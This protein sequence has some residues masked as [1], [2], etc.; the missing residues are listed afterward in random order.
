MMYLRG[1]RDIKPGP[2][3]C[4]QLEYTSNTLSRSLALNFLD[5]VP[6][7]FYEKIPVSK[8]APSASK[9]AML[10]FV[11]C[12]FLRSNMTRDSP[13]L[14]RRYRSAGSFHRS[15]G[16]GD[17][18]RP[19]FPVSAG[20]QNGTVG[21]VLPPLSFTLDKPGLFAPMYSAFVAGFCIFERADRRH[22]VKGGFER[23]APLRQLLRDIRARADQKKRVALSPRREA[24]NEGQL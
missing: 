12:S 2:A 7:R 22:F 18:R 3:T 11:A 8:E 15:V 1:L 23:A 21:W 6:S 9:N 13:V 10:R 24:R 20:K 4:R 5:S 19:A 14:R 16:E 17:R